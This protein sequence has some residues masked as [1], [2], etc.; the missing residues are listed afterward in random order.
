MKPMTVKDAADEVLRDIYRA[1][2]G[3]GLKKAERGLPKGTLCDACNE[4]IKWRVAQ[5][6]SLVVNGRESHKGE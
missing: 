5:M 6:I 2:H 4:E 1:W 3:C